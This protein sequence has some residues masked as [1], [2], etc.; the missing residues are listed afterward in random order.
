MKKTNHLAVLTLALCFALISSFKAFARDFYQIKIYSI[1]SSEQEKVIDQYLE[2]AYLPALHRQGIESVGV[3]KPRTETDDAGKKIYVLVPLTSMDQ[4]L[5]IEEKLASDQIYQKAGAAY[6]NAPHDKAPF[7]RIESIILRAFVDAPQMNLPKLNGP[8]SERFYE[9]RSYEGPTEKKYVNKVD[10]FNAG[11]EVALFSDL[12]FNAVF[13]GEV[14]SGSHM[15]NLMYMTTFENR[16]DRDAHWKKF[17]DSPV[18]TKLKNDPNYQ[19]NVSKNTQYY[20]YPTEYS[21]I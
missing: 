6:I 1:S 17:V 18:W 4:V 16:A 10:M 8:K 5:E 9:L 14:I 21:D 12:D 20:L 11:G 15:P 2:H 19:N 13:Y 7:D 3:L